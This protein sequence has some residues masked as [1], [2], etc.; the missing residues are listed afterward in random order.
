MCAP[1][2]L[3]VCR[4]Q[5]SLRRGN[6]ALQLGGA[7]HEAAVSQRKADGTL[8]PAWQGRDQRPEGAPT[9]GTWRADGRVCKRHR[10]RT[11]RNVLRKLRARLCAG[12]AALWTTRVLWAGAL[13]ALAWP[14]PG[15]SPWSAAHRCKAGSEAGCAVQ[16]LGRLQARAL[17]PAEERGEAGP[18]IACPAGGG[19]PRSGGR[20]DRGGHGFVLGKGHQSQVPER[21]GYRLRAALKEHL[22]VLR[23]GVHS[24][25][26]AL[27][28]RAKGREVPATEHGHARAH[29]D[30]AAASDCARLPRA[31]ACSCQQC[32]RSP[33]ARPDSRIR[34]RR[35]LQ[36]HPAPTAGT[37]PGPRDVQA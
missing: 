36:L 16:E 4:P 26:G 28:S 21:H 7:L 33:G 15:P 11:G 12:R 3:L 9:L 20:S 37:G 13:S 25:H 32:H 24:E 34:R 8:R 2:E 19:L 14:R 1:V 27:V 30:A 29:G 17:W 22:A 5:P 23:L 31:R 18:A 6:V 35:T 10:A